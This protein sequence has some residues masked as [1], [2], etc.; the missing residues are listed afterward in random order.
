MKQAPHGFTGGVVLAAFKP[1]AGAIEDAGVPQVL[2]LPLNRH[3]GT[4]GVAVVAAGERVARFQVI[5]RAG[6]Y[7]GVPLHAP[8]SGVVLAA[9]PE[10]ILI[11]AD[12]LDRGAPADPIDWPVASPAQLRD[13]IGAA[14]IVGMGGAGFPARVKLRE[15]AARAPRMLIVNA[16]ECEPSIGCDRALLRHR[17]REVFD[18]ARILAR[19]SGAPRCVLAVKQG[20]DVPQDSG[21]IEVIAVPARYPAGGEKQLIQALC[22]I[23]LASGALPIEAGVLMH[24]VGTAA[25]VYAAVVRGEPLVSRVVTVA[26]AVARPGN[27]QVRIGTPI[28][29]LIERAGGAAVAGARILSGGPM[30][31][32]PVDDPGAPIVGTTNGV[33]LLAPSAPVA[34]QPCI[35]CG[36]C[37][38]VCP[39]QL[40][41]Q[42]LLAAAREGNFDRAQDLHLFDCIECGC[43]AYVCPSRIGL[44]GEYRAAKSAVMQADAAWRAAQSA[45]ARHDAHE[46]RIARAPPSPSATSA[47]A[48]RQDYIAAAIARARRDGNGG[49]C[50]P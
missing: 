4:P 19:A 46:V 5:A 10:S 3:V 18:G 37:I 38:E 41:P 15:A 34:E 50:P 7:V 29:Y 22:G 47:R 26:G 23:E 14:G 35:R 28:A 31:G 27:F 42:A 32:H 44:V 21:G 9:G 12:G 1:D 45:R 11:Q 20:D 36:R 8:T 39:V 43:C 16:V 17:A 48:P 24:N 2:H 6:S 49:D 33:L 13:A 30:M 25:A 40:Q